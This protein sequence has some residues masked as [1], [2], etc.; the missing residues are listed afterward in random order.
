MGQEVVFRFEKLD[1]W[2]LARA[3][4]VEVYRL[5]NEF[6]H[7]ERFGLTAQVRRSAVSVA[8][9]IAEGSGRNSDRDFAHFL[10]MSYGSLMEVVAQLTAAHDLGYVHESKLTEFRANC[11]TLAGK[12]V[13]LNRSLTVCTR[14]PVS[15][16]RAPALDP[17]P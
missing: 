11:S 3:L 17:R 1:V 13:V 7:E 12:L 8:S 4:I 6:P 5:T 2:Q 10:E 14:K 9:N 15:A 16:N